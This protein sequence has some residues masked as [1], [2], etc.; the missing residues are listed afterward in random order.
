MEKVKDYVVVMKQYP[1][2]MTEAVREYVKKG[3]QPYGP[4]QITKVVGSD[5]TREKFVQ[6][7]VLY[8]E[9]KNKQK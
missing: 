1:Y 5:G 7:L 2:D 4:M 6:A 3:Y 9:E 8:E